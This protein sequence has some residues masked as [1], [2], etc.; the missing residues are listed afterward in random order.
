MF[1]IVF[2]MLS[3]VTV[4]CVNAVLLAGAVDKVYECTQ[5]GKQC[6]TSKQLAHHVQTHSTERPFRCMQVLEYFILLHF[7]E[8]GSFEVLGICQCV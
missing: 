2:Q 6:S 8:I 5:C 1:V 3:T 7:V 4:Q